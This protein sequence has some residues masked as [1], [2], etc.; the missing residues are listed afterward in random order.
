MTLPSAVR[1]AEI[2]EFVTFI[3]IKACPQLDC[4]L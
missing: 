4:P 3:F 1:Q 2:S